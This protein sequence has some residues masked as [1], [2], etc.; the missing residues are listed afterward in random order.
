MRVGVCVCVYGIRMFVVCM[1]KQL[2]ESA[3]SGVSCIRL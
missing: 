2:C 1:Y 3:C